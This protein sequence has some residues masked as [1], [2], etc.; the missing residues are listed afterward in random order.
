M[1]NIYKPP[2]TE[3]IEVGELLAHAASSPT[4]IGGDFNYQHLFLCS[5]GRT[6]SAGRQLQVALS[7]TPG[8]GLLNNGEP[9][10]INGGRL[11]LSFVTD[12]L[13]PLDHPPHSH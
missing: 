6:N 3:P 11:H 8:V 2:N 4:L 13:R 12:V 1:Y 10:H 5:P 7:G 9:T